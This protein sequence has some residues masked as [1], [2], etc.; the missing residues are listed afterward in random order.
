MIFLARNL[1]WVRG[2]SSQPCYVWL[3]EGIHAWRTPLLCENSTL[4]PCS[5]RQLFDCLRWTSEATELTM[6]I[7]EDLGSIIRRTVTRGFLLTTKDLQWC[8]QN[9]WRCCFC[10][11]NQRDTI[12]IQNRHPNICIWLCAKRWLPKVPWLTTILPLKIV[13]RGYNMAVAVHT[14]FVWRLLFGMIWCLSSLSC[15]NPDSSWSCRQR[16][17]RHVDQQPSTWRF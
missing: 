6:M 4:I 7:F 9:S 12:D 14:Y 2:F 3:P 15:K 16:F 17:L 8:R 11:S 1:H 13:I 10:L 5:F